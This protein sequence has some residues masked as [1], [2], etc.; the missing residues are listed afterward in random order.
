MI[1]VVE[2]NNG[3]GKKLRT[4]GLKI[5]A[6]SGSAQNSQ[7]KTTHAWI[8]GYFPVDNPEVVFV[9]FLQGAGSGGSVAGAVAK[10]FI[11]EYLRLYGKNEKG[12]K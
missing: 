5:A 8:A 4:P 11:D 10:E 7:F 6:K 3:T 12:E 1:G 2:E 9:V